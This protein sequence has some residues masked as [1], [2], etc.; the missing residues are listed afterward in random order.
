VIETVEI[1]QAALETLPR[2]PHEWSPGLDK[3][4]HRDGSIH[5]PGH[6]VSTGETSGAA[7]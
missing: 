3:L 5:E 4:D 6:P 2:H 7:A 1:P